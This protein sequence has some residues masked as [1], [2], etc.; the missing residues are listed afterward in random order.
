MVGGVFWRAE[1]ARKAA[2]KLAKK[3][4]LVVD[5]VVDEMDVWRSW[6]FDRP[7]LLL[8][9]RFIGQRPV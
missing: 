7:V 2:K 1:C 3:G 4:R 6:R 8:S 5:M 9:R